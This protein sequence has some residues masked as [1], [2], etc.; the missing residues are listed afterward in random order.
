MCFSAA[1]A[2]VPIGT[3][4]VMTATS[5]FEIDAPG[6]VGGEDRIARPDEAVRAALIHQRIGPEARRH[7][8]AARFAH[9]FDM[10]D[11]GRAIGPLIGAGQ[12]RR[13]VF[14]I[15]R[16][17]ARDRALV[18]QIVDAHQTRRGFVP[19]V[20]RVL[21]CRRDMAGATQRVRS[22]DTTTSA[23]SRPDFRDASFMR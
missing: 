12:R 13:A 14:R 1:P 11:V 8:G 20:H 2:F 7:L 4:S 22:R 17:L 15:E 9:Q 18:H 21:Q 23:P 19:V 10:R 3:S 16:L 6:F 5:A